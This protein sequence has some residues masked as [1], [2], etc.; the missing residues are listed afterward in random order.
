MD[1]AH[2]AELLPGVASDDDLSAEADKI[3]PHITRSTHK[4]TR[5]RRIQNLY[6]R[7]AY[8]VLMLTPST[9]YTRV[10]C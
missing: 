4:V 8:E 2:A 3:S 6:Q 10:L 5:I 9:L 1:V 7:R